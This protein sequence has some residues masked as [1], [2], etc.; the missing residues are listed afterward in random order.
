MLDLNAR[1]VVIPDLSLVLS[2]TPFLGSY[3]AVP[4][5][6]TEAER[7]SFSRLTPDA[8]T[9][10]TEPIQ[11]AGMLSQWFFRGLLSITFK[12]KPDTVSC[13][14]KEFKLFVSYVLQDRAPSHEH[15]M[16]F[17]TW[18]IHVCCESVTYQTRN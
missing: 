12:L 15:K 13:T 3:K 5:I 6:Y 16:A 17:L 11:I 14:E 8:L 18:V 10:I 4:Q 7:R 1:P 2:I 9:T